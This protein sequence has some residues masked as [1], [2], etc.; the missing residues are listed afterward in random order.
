MVAVGGVGQGQGPVS[1]FVISNKERAEQAI[2]SKIR[3]A[4]QNP[5]KTIREIQQP[6][7]LSQF[8]DIKI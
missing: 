6:S 2:E 8:L 3:E 5:E 4:L 7:P 1:Q